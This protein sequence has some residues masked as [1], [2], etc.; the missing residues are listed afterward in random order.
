[1]QQVKNNEDIDFLD[2]F[3]AFNIFIINLFIWP[4]IILVTG[5]EKYLGD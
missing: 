1:M 4:N 3:V 5:I 2:I